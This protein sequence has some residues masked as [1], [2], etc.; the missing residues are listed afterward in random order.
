MTSPMARGFGR[1]VPVALAAA[2]AIGLP[3]AAVADNFPEKPIKLIVPFGPGG[4]PDVAA[5]IIGAYLS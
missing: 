5:R 2:I 3:A 1:Y 4:P